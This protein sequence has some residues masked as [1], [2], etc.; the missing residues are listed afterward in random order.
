MLTV[1]N[2]GEGPA[3]LINLHC[4]GVTGRAW[5]AKDPHK[6]GVGRKPFLQVLS[7]EP[8]HGRPMR[9]A[10]GYLF[11]PSS[12]ASRPQRIRA[13]SRRDVEAHLRQARDA[14]TRG[15]PAAALDAF[16]EA[17]AGR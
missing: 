9:L 14:L 5:K 10:Q 4:A 8:W 12:A 15:D 3:E 16:N 7:S 17:L 1:P 13:L 11:P 2:A 6:A